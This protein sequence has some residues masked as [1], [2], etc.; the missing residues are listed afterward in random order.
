M[1]QSIEQHAEP[2]HVPYNIIFAAL[3]FL[4]VVTV[5]I[6]RIHL[7]L[8]GNWALALLVA[9]VKGSLVAAYFMHLK[10]EK[11]HLVWVLLVPVF[12]ALALIVGLLP[13]LVF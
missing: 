7:G 4:T 11:K 6:S 12:Y 8:A 3:V 5:G 2:E 1:E 13:D 9:G 10:F